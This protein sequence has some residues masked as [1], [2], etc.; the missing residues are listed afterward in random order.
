MI[1]K[2]LKIVGI[3]FLVLLLLIVALPFFFGGT[4]EDKIKYMANQN[5][6]AQVNFEDVNISLFR[7]FPQVAVTIDNLSV[8]NNA[9]F[10]G[11]TLV[12][13]KEIALDMSIRELFKSAEESIKI[14]K[15][16]VDEATMN[17]KVNK[18]G[19]A[20]Y[21]IAKEDNV[22]PTTEA[23]SSEGFTFDLDHYEINESN[24]RYTDQ[25]VKTDLLLS[26]LNHTGDGTISGNKM[27]L[28]TASLTE[29]SFGMDSINYL[30]KTKLKL[31]AIIEL[32][33]K[34]QK[35]TLRENK[36][37]INQLPL[38]FEGFV[39][40]FE[41]Y[42]DV[43]IRF[44]T[45][46]SDFKNF[47]AVIPATYAKNLDGVKTSGDF[48]V[49][50]SI[51]GKT[52]DTLIPKMNIKILSNN[53]SFKYPDLPKSVRN[54]NINAVIKNETGLVADTFILLDRLTFAI[55]EDT[56]SANGSF[57][58]ITENM[59]VDMVLKG[60]LNLQNLDKA[61]PLKLD[62]EL[63][64]RIR[65]DIATKFDMLSLEKE[66]YQN[67]KS[68]GT[69]N[70]NDFAY[71]SPEIPNELKIANAVVQFSPGTITL[72]E[73]TATTGQSDVTAKGTLKNLMGFLFTKQD[74]KGD[75]NM[76]SNVFAVNDFMV[77]APN[78]ENTQ[79]ITA[80][81]ETE[82]L[83]IP[84]FLDATIVFT[85]N[86]VLYDNLEL[87]NTK[88]TVIIKDETASLREVTSQIFDGNIGF[89]GNVRTNSDIPTFD[90]N[91]DLSKIDITK[92][93][94]SMELLQGLAPI[95]KALTGALSTDLK[96]NGQLSKDLSPVLSSLKGNAIAEILNAK[97]SADKTPLL[98]NLN[99]RIKFIDVDK[100]DLKDIKTNLTFDDGKINVKP[101]LFDV[102]GIKVQAGGSHGFDMNMNY[103]VTLDVP[104]KYLGNEAS[105]LLSQLS[106]QEVQNMKV[107]IPI[108][109]TGN[110][111]NPNIKM[112]A[113]QAVK[114]LTQQIISTQKQ[115]ATDE[116]RSKGTE[117]LGGL[118]GNKKG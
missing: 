109:I 87:A 110:F 74:L 35:Y 114:N 93:F 52:D 68:T 57:R 91:L 46:N 29:A 22:S 79:E 55:D 80:T 23:E 98:S 88:G 50:G 66:Q 69:I 19:K 67:V 8:I 117:I 14:R 65:A 24:I 2:I 6:N 62:Q 53:A 106:A 12:F 107:A 73:M 31:D 100:L 48:I 71:R 95:A 44:K 26:N 103:N 27:I 54:I 38:E 92:S 101:F 76:A 17:I 78:S 32:D 81:T 41:N 108:G 18:S 59:L 1:K 63:N 86:K 58:N 51:I 5:V 10:A 7:S 34:N 85:A 13:A 11:D 75:F 9:P 84:S 56:F 28:N 89:S 42:T 45:P 20:N 3:I 99:S 64:G 90:M 118:L 47:L 83:K 33:L 25:S 16:L 115:K 4:I 113:G 82:G 60:N 40:L 105:G 39:Q 37:L 70:L 104:A 30:D 72:N 94:V 112:D 49:D 21:D 96:L 36:A 15:F 43:D 102:K 61:Y 111:S 97:V 77:A 116:I